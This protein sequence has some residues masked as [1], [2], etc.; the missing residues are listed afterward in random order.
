MRSRFLILA[1]LVTGLAASGVRAADKPAAKITFDEHVL[2]IL[3]ESCAACHGADK[4]RGGLAVHTFAATMQGGGSG[5]VVKSGDPDGSRLYL[6]MAHK[7]E[8]VMPP[9][10]PKL[11]QAK[12]D[13]VN[14]WIAGGALENSGSKPVAPKPRTEVGLTS[15]VRGR[16]P[17][18][19]MPA[20]P[21]PQEPAVKTARGNAVT[22]LTASPWAPL[23][24]VGGQKQVL[25]YNTDTL[26][27]AG[28]LPFPEG[29]P[30]VL[31][32]SRNGSLL[33]AGGGHAAKSGKV[34]VWSVATGERIIEVGDETDTVLAADISPDQTHIALGGPSKMV[35][36]YS[37]RDGQKVREIKKHT[38]W[39]YAL[40]FSPDGVLLATADR[41]GGLFVWEAFTGREYFT[42]RGHT[43]AV[44]DLSWRDDSNV[45]ASISEDTTVKLWEME[46]GTPI[47]SWG[48]HGGGGLGVRFGHDNRLVSAGRDRVVKMWDQNGAAQRA[49]EALPDLA[50]RAAFTHDGA[51]VAGS[52]WTG[53]VRLWTAADG[54]PVGTLT[55][56]PPSPAERL[57]AAVKDLAAREAAL[58]QATAA[59]TA[60]NA[61]AQKAATDLAAAQQAAAAMAAAV[62]TTA[63]QAAAAKAAADQAA[64]AVKPAQ[65]AAT[66][67]EL[68]AKVHAEAA[69]K[70]K[71]AADGAKDNK[72][73]AALAARAAALAATAATD[74]A[75]AQKSAAE[76]AAAAKAKTEALTKAQQAAVAAGPAAA[77]AAKNVEALQAAMKA[78]QA[79]AAVDKAAVA[80]AAAAVQEA[81]T[82]VE[83][84]KAA[85]AVVQKPAP[86]APPPAAPPTAA[87]PAKPAAAP[88]TPAAPKPG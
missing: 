50:V 79:R 13:L 30:Q 36:I 85:T 24:A 18:P 19:P 87:A 31:K 59:L 16:P 45:L 7:D 75:A 40:E 81:R 35:R 73:L 67:R 84:L 78:A 14:K 1:A 55:T 66:A 20:R 71:A 56:N 51:R 76:A 9:K 21:L 74:L 53:Q 80:A 77:A 15:I 52:D 43:A 64:A 33:L 8:P 25:L 17:V 70:L 6:L 86:A 4:Q 57:E 69:A 58:A 47:K 37:T 82:R 32:F 62:K 44:T 11:D 60:A 27:L 41:A 5:A 10:S 22:A 61:A 26:D 48:A 42:L 23:L 54:K 34:V 63:D 49:F 2:P 68:A 3:R 39:I 29:V 88:A 72:E 65:D 38:D 83:R 28:V 46:N 12:L